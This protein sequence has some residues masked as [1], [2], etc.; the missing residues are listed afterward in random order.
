MPVRLW[1]YIAADLW[2][3]LL[4]TAAVLVTVIAFAITIPPLADGKLTPLDAIKFMAL[5][6]V[7]MLAYA[8][9]FA[10]GFAST[11]VYHRIA[12]DNEAAAAHAGGIGHRSLLAPALA[13]GVAL[14]VLLG[15][16]SDQAIPR[17]LRSMERYV[18]LDIAEWM[19]VQLG[20]GNAFEFGGTL[21]AAEAVRALDPRDVPGANDA[22]S[23]VALTRPAILFL[24][25]DDSVR[26]AATAEIAW[27]VVRPTPSPWEGPDAGAGTGAD[28][29]PRF[30]SIVTLIAQNYRAAGD[31]SIIRSE[32]RFRYDIAVPPVIGDDPKFFTFAELAELRRH[33]E[34]FDFIDEFRHRLA[35]R[36]AAVEFLESVNSQLRAAGSATLTTDTGAG[37]TIHAPALGP[38]PSLTRRVVA[39]PPGAPLRIEIRHAD[40]SPPETLAAAS[41]VLNAFYQDEL[42]VPRVQIRLELQNV[43]SSGRNSAEAL[44]Q[45]AASD[46]PVAGV[47][48]QRTIATL[49]DPSPRYT[50]LRAMT[51][52]QIMQ[53]TLPYTQPPTPFE[54]AVEAHQRLRDMERRLQ[55]EITA[56]EHERVAMSLAGMVM[57]L[58]GSAVAIKLKHALPLTVYLWAFFPALA[59]V[60]VIS[61]GKQLTHE[62][63]PVGLLPLWLGVLAPLAYALVT[64]RQI[65][66]R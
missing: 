21:L 54:G 30:G 5:A 29:D 3:R 4:I 51:F 66:R 1:R 53:E 43:A 28:G 2:R 56:N 15:V 55:H 60:L 50:Q 19:I 24:N 46:Q 31:D 63:G 45:A 65:A 37:V 38:G 25:A 48:R 59:S 62:F 7:P 58:T 9:P 10:A 35:L 22:Q 13:S 40:G 34:R 52:D 27:L 12:Q 64:Y 11:L 61:M 6:T 26:T 57:V 32:S 44:R 8:V 47:R 41:A 23:V 42:T 39:E 17:F 18:R 20:L 14:A 49:L 33:P 36:T 16:I